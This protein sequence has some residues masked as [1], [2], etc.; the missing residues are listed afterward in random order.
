MT[1]RRAQISTFETSLG[2]LPGLKDQDRLRLYASAEGYVKHQQACEKRR[3]SRLA[4]LKEQKA[5]ADVQQREVRAIVLNCRTV[6]LEMADELM[7]EVSPSSRAALEVL[8]QDT[9][10]GTSIT[11]EEHE[12][13]FFRLPR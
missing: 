3:D 8:I 9:K 6:T 7:N 11:V 2:R 4:E 13:E 12:L 10:S 5:S 1:S